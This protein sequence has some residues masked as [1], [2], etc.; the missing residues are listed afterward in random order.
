MPAVP[1]F[2]NTTRLHV[3]VGHLPQ[4][5]GLD[6]WKGQNDRVVLR[7][8]DFPLREEAVDRLL[9]TGKF[10]PRVSH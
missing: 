7:L 9:V 2:V 1:H 4:N 6:S 10:Q 5:G 8:L 3:M